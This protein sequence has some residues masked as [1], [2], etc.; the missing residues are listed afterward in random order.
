M[1]VT[2]LVLIPDR[3]TIANQMIAQVLHSFDADEGKGMVDA[4]FLTLANTDIKLHK[5]QTVMV[6]YSVIMCQLLSCVCRQ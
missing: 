1:Q 6:S 4:V 3:R 2:P 5:N